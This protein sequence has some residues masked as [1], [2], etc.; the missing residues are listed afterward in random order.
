M[1]ERRRLIAACAGLCA[2]AACC[3]LL[4]TEREP[5]ADALR[6]IAVLPQH[7]AIKQPAARFIQ[8]TLAGL[9]SD[10]DEK[11]HG[12]DL[13]RHARIAAAQTGAPGKKTRRA[14]HG[15]KTSSALDP[16]AKST[17]FDQFERGQT[18]AELQRSLGSPLFSAEKKARRLPLAESAM[19]A[20]LER[21]KLPGPLAGIPKDM[22][23]KAKAHTTMLTDNLRYR[24]LNTGYPE[25]RV[26]Y[27]PREGGTLMEGGV[28]TGEAGAWDG[29]DHWLD[30]Q[31]PIEETFSQN[32]GTQPAPGHPDGFAVNK[33]WA[34]VFGVRRGR[35]V[36][37]RPTQLAELEGAEVEDHN[38]IP[39]LKLD[40]M[41]RRTS[42]SSLR[43]SSTFSAD[44]SSSSPQK[45]E[46][47]RESE[48]R[49]KTTPDRP[50][51]YVQPREAQ[52]DAEQSDRK[53]PHQTEHS[54][55][56]EMQKAA[57]LAEGS[58][59]P[60][61]AGGGVLNARGAARSM[62]DGAV[63]DDE[64]SDAMSTLRSAMSDS[65]QKSPGHREAVAREP[66]L[67]NRLCVPRVPF[68]LVQISESINPF[69]GDCPPLTMSQCDRG[70]LST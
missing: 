7:I 66:R 12:H 45:R 67:T 65:R 27:V 36:S 47:G 49:A 5:R 57:W 46:Q 54:P 48:E 17:A 61:N 13:H 21:S 41:P 43:S 53:M 10:A 59:G 51:E 44:F 15:K 9:T 62:E 70:K 25:D 34:P 56:A 4:R 22:L 18:L 16:D 58:Q 3:M 33:Y 50:S 38:G 23:A 2:A 19:I 31:V 64:E 28:N 37:G 32:F 26:E 35:G 14:G 6:S 30:E 52:R 20:K 69:E 8:Q 39:E 55:E 11:L 24:G 40:V 63:A 60:V 1:M 42:R 68:S 29:E